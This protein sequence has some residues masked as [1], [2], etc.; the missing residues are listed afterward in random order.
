MKSFSS[1]VIGVLCVIVFA[2]GAAALELPAV[3]SDGMV[4]QRDMPVAVWGKA[5]PGRSVAVSLGLHEAHGIAGA[6]GR[7]RV[8]LPA[9][10]ASAEPRQLL[11]VE[12]PF[13]D[14]SGGGPPPHHVEL[15]IH[16]V[17]VGDVWH[18]SGQSN[19]SWTVA[20]SND[21]ETEI[22]AA[23]FPNV[24]LFRVPNTAAETPQF[25]SGGAWLRATPEHVENFSAVAYFFGRK[26]NASQGVPIGLVVT[27]WGGASAEAYTS[28]DSQ[29][30]NPIIDDELIA[31]RDELKR[32]RERGGPAV[33]PSQLPERQVDPGLTE[34]SAAYLRPGFDDAQWAQVDLPAMIESTELGNIDGGVWFR[35]TVT[36][37]EAWGGRPL[38][39]GLGP[40]DDFDQ[41]FVNGQPVGGIGP[42]D[43]RAYARPR[44][45]PVPADLVES[46]SVTV[47]V[48][49]FD[50]F[51]NGGF[52]GSAQAMT[53]SLA[54][55]A[56]NTG[57]ALVS[58][59]GA[60]RAFADQ[61][62]SPDGLRAAVKGRQPQHTPAALLNG[63]IH[64]VAP[65]AHRG[66]LWYQGETNA[67]RGPAYRTLLPTMIEDWRT[68]WGQPGDHRDTPFL[69]VQ[70]ANY[71]EPTPQPPAADGWGELRDSQTAVAAS[72]NNAY[73]MTAIDIGQADDIHPRNK[74]DVGLRLARLAEH[75]VYGDASV[76]PVGPTMLEVSNTIELSSGAIVF[77]EHA[78]VL[79][80]IDGQP[81]R[82][83]AMRPIDGE[84]PWVWAEAAIREDA[85]ATV[86][87]LEHPEGLKGPFEIR[88]A[89]GINPADGPQG[90][91]LVNGEGLP[92]MPFRTDPV[93]QPD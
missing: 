57:A 25:S 46:T 84:Q 36:I 56:D 78:K 21:A 90:I 51:G 30:N 15:K 2:A 69:I 22:A 86:V 4:L 26:L 92:A 39:L 79:K 44:L 10:N 41:T 73:V 27:S 34:A 65:L 88:Y 3:F 31:Y 35:K 7:W 1:R 59:A 91:N 63:M 33:D 23:D 70:L 62:M 87:R 81:P 68:L 75:Y 72:V 48:R 5:E 18:C 12:G 80:T 64:P 11:V 20:N 45:Y 67:W 37:P 16:D 19:M 74:Q 77:W 49:V 32:I 50:H 42:D 60:W 17:L 93:P 8:D 89:Y 61:P 71:Q 66:V 43:P 28:I 14:S 55:D 29:E 24:R 58:L 9:L 53:L 38:V 13:V 6:D 76:V 83:F 47:A 52:S 82:G 85:V 54:V 40:V